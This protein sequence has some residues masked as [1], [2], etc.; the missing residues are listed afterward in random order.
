MS[1]QTN[2][3]H[4]ASA[5]WR[6]AGDAVQNCLDAGA[7]EFV[8]CGGAR[9]AAILEHLARLENAGTIRV[10]SHFEERSAAFF[11]LGRTI[12]TGRPCVVVTTSGTAA[13]ELLPAVIEAFYQARPLIALTADRPAAARG[14]GAPQTIMQPG[15]FGPHAHHD[16]TIRWN[17]RCP[18]HINAELPEAL[19]IPEP[20]E[21]DGPARPA[22]PAIFSPQW[23]KPNVAELAR[24]IRQPGLRGTIIA[25]GGLESDEREE[26]WHFCNTLALPVIAEATSG[27]RE[28]LNHLHLPDA[29]HLLRHQQPSKIL[30]L[31]DCPSGRF[32]RDL[33]DQ[34]DVD[35]WSIC[36]NGLRGLV[37]N[38]N[39]IQG[40]VHRVL[41]ALGDVAPLGDINDH[42]ASRGRASSRIDEMLEAHPDSEPALIRA[43][44]R[45]AIFAGPLFLGNSMPIR[46]WNLFA[47]TDAPAPEIR[48]NRGAN[49]I[50]G[51]LSTWLGA[52]ADDQAAWAIVGDLTAL[53]D[54]AAA[55][56]LGQVERRQRVLAVINNNGGRIFTRLPRLNS[57]S[58]KAQNWLIHPTTADFA[59]FASLWGMRHHRI[60]TQDDLDA[61]DPQVADATLL[62]ITPCPR[63]TSAF[64]HAWDN[65]H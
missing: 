29:D 59:A 26:T 46:E 54:P 35:V 13:A 40:Q 21:P 32:W 8:V 7:T 56:I 6:I 57:L 14:S 51:Q 53:Y 48:A 20:G 2:E 61:F 28:S 47:Q 39:V 3:N 58:Q 63:D 16:P 15:I 9:N 12:T 17:G 50:D 52:T 24:W 30:R 64:W 45:Y 31:G 10:W 34:P 19:D 41:R 11:A 38:A 49:G 42:L 22:T 36:R 65:R 43:L 27:L 4:P 62:E 37:R 1:E 55:A 5:T 33:D 18:L 25:I 60:S 23:E 44:S